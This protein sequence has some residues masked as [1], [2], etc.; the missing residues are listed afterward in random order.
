MPTAASITIKKKDGT[1]NIVYDLIS[2]SGGDNSPTVYRQDTGNAVGLPVGLRPTFRVMSKWNGSRTARQ[3]NHEFEYPYAV[4][5]TTTTRYE[6]T[7]K[8]VFK[9]GTLSVPQGIPSD[10]IAEATAQYSN[11]IGSAE[12]KA[13]LAAGYAAT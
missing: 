9:N 10:V 2:A 3:L 12:M 4:Q 5:N 1:T 7:D 11:L 6:S 13:M 8:V